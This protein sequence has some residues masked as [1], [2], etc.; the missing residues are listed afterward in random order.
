MLCFCM[1]LYLSDT[2]GI[3]SKTRGDPCVVLYS[4]DFVLNDLLHFVLRGLDS[5]SQKNHWLVSEFII[6]NL[7]VFY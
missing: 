5:F 7:L 1:R 3:A 6:V 4:S 2:I